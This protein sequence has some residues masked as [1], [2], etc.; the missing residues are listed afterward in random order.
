MKNIVILSTEQWGKMLLSKMHFAIHLADMGYKVYFVNTPAYINSLKL[1]SVNKKDSSDNITVIDIKKIKAS[2]FLRYKFFWLYEQLSKRY[3]KSIQKII[4]EKISEVWSFDPHMYVNL[5]QFDGA[6]TILML[7]DFY[8]GKHVF[9]AAQSADVIV[10][11]SKL[12]LDH[13]K[14]AKPPKLLLQHGLSRYFA[15]IAASNMIQENLFISK[16]D[17]IR[18]GYMGNLLIGGLNITLAENIIKQNCDKEFH[19]WGPYS[20]TDNNVTSKD[21]I[22][23]SQRTH[24]IEFLKSQQNVFLHGI[25]EQKALASEL[26]EM[27][28]FLFLYSANSDMNKASNSHKIL[29]YLSTGKA[30][31]STFVSNYAETDLLVM[32]KPGR[33]E[34]LPEIFSN[35]VNNLPLY[36]SEK[37]QKK[38]IA[39]A[40]DNTYLR[41]IGRIRNF[42]YQDELK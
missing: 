41:Q 26:N 34:D 4:G 13:Y 3:V 37:E 12:I 27:D 30:I 20:L 32:S 25:K 29:E 21:A 10:S 36:N 17:K 24:F 16:N 31:I 8:K 38:R 39:F 6:K 19:F 42:L 22:I 9:K 23:D 11:I 18:I 33:D 2:L 1:A 40:L 35:V 14:D 15:D 5:K 28:G 7:Y